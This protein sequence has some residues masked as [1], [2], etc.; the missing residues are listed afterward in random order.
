MQVMRRGT[1]EPGGSQEGSDRWTSIRLGLRLGE[2]SL[3]QRVS[4]RVGPCASRPV[5][6]G[7]ACERLSVSRVSGSSGSL[8]HGGGPQDPGA[9]TETENESGL[10]GLGS[11]ML[12]IIRFD[13]GRKR[14][15]N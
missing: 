6:G 15:F 1:R 10:E 13:G 12:M 7:G 2:W 11:I 3:G 5:S 8:R 4:L 14:D 9:E